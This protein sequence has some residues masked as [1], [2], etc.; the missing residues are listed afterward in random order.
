MTVAELILKLQKVPQ[1]YTVYI[2][3]TEQFFKVSNVTRYSGSGLKNVVLI[4]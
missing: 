4:T 3:D 1:G 2:D